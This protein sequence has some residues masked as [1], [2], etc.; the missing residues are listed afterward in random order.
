MVMAMLTCTPTAETLQA[1]SKHIGSISIVKDNKHN[2][3]TS[4]PNIKESKVDLQANCRD[5]V[6][7][8]LSSKAATERSIL[9]LFD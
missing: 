3:I 7:R 9:A 2:D 5:T 6:R 1:F 4:L 8:L